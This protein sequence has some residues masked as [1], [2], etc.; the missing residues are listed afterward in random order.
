MTASE[1]FCLKWN[2]FQK[3]VSSSFQEIRE[4]FCDVTLA[5]EGN[6]KILAHKVILATSSNFFRDVLKNN[7]HPHP[8]LYMK[9]IKEIHLTAVVDFMYNGEVNIFQEDLDDFLSV[10]GELQLKG[11]QANETETKEPKQEPNLQQPL[12]NPRKKSMS[13]A[14]ITDYSAI[15]SISLDNLQD[16][17]TKVELDVYE[18]D[19]KRAMVEVYAT[20]NKVTTTNEELD[21]RIR[22]MMNR[23]DGQWSCNLCGKTHR[24]K[25]VVTF[26]IEAKHIEGVTHPCNKCGKLFRSRHSLAQHISSNHKHP[27]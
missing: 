6:H 3:N 10:A 20:D 18:I 7:Q 8:L 21:E 11:L 24:D 25:Q 23:S 4:D 2:D 27:K 12:I 13:K 26:H 14:A 17:E 16:Y 1:K 19:D 9:G 15:K 22:S 5:G